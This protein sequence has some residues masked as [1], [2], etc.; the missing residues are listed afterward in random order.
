MAVYTGVLGDYTVSASSV[1][2]S[3]ASRDGS[4][5]LSTWKCCSSLP[6][7]NTYYLIASGKRGESVNVQWSLLQR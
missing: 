4:D 7:R 5:S 6:A 1:V 2:D 3:N